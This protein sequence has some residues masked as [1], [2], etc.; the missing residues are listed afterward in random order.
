MKYTLE[1]ATSKDIEQLRKYKISNIVDFA[2]ELS[3]EEYEQIENY[4]NDTIS[5]QLNN[6]QIIK[7]NQ[8][9]IGCLCIESHEDGVLVDEIY[10]E[11]DYRHKGIGTNILKDILNQY[12]TIYLWVYKNNKMAW[13][14][15]RKLGFHAIQETQTRLF[16]KYEKSTGLC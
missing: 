10:I 5:H 1:N 6:Y 14:L 3:K 13:Q 4:V 12:P 15:Y 9:K 7:V 2:K 8:E 11:K 16:M